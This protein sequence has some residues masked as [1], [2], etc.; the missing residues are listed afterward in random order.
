MTKGRTYPY[1]ASYSPLIYPEEEWAP[2]LRKMQAASMNLVR[3]GD[4]HGSWDRI[5]P[6]EGHLRLDLLARFYT[7][8]A[9]YGIRVLLSNG[10]ACPPLWLARKYPDVRLLSSRGERY[11]LAASYHW[12]CIHHPGFLAEARRY[13]AALAEFAA[14]Q[15]NHFGWQISNELGFPFMPAHGRDELGLYCYCQHCKARFR[16]WVQAKYGTLEALSHAWTWSTTAF[17]YN[18]WEDVE[19]PEALPYAW[20]GVTRWID[21]RLFWQDAFADFAGWQHALIHNIDPDHPTSVNTFNFKS[22]DRFGTF[23]GLDQWKI[24]QRVDHVGYDLYPG[25]G[26]KLKTRPEHNSIFLDHGRSVSRSAGADFWLHEMESGPINGWV[27][28]PDHNTGPDDILRNGLEA[29][30]HDVKLG[31]F[32]PWREWDYQPIRWGALVDLDGAPTPRH[33]AA[34]ELGQFL[35]AHADFLLDAHVPRGEVAI[36]ETKPNA[37]FF[38]GLDQERPLF[39]AQRGAYRAFW[40]LGYRVDFVTSAQLLEGAAEGYRV[41]A[42]PLMALLSAEAA[43]ALRAYVEG[44]GLLVGFARCATLDRRGWYH[45]PLPIA[46][47]RDAFGLCGVTADDRADDPVT[48]GGQTYAGHMKRDLVQSAAETEVLSTFPDGRPAVTLASY[49]AGHGLYFATQA[50]AGYVETERA[51]LRPVLESVL[52]RL[53]IT[54][55]LQLGYPGRERKLDPHLLR[56]DDRDML[57]IANYLPGRVDTSLKMNAFRNVESVRQIWPHPSNVAWTLENDQLTCDLS[58]ERGK[59]G[60]IEIRW[61]S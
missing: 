5:E 26:D 13:T 29:L 3:I 17:W 11:P 55:E 33:D 47:L 1:G 20:S 23:M 48:F 57:I 16:E 31:I 4:V 42:L 22:H 6:Q 25:S 7:T 19:P 44:G 61:Q 27:L 21:W 28:G 15:P 12:A 58:F 18:A 49:G 32:M 14:T 59:G 54:P 36:L 2:D 40:E 51:L 52:G 39:Q 56:G 53:R 37:I 38:R 50:D 41:V 46:P 34:A 24:A 30:G 8:A 35:Q 10:T 43:E 45:H 9:D 60:V